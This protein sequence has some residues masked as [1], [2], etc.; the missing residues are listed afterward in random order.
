MFT[1]TERKFYDEFTGL[2]GGGVDYLNALQGDKITCIVK[3]FFYWAVTGVNVNFN[4]GTKTISLFGLS[5][6]T[7]N[8]FLLNGFKIGDSIAIVGS[9]TNDGTYTIANVTDTVITT[10]Q[11]LNT[12]NGPDSSIYG[13]TLIT[14]LDYYFD[15]IDN[16]SQKS[17]FVSATDKGTVQKYSATGLDASVATPVSLSIATQSRG[18]SSDILS[19]NF[20]EGTVIGVSNAGYKQSFKITTVF[21]MTRIWT[22]EL[23]NNFSNRSA[24]EEYKNGNCLKHVC[25]ID[26]KF[27]QYDPIISHTGSLLNQQAATGWFNQSNTQK[28][29]EYT[30]GSIQYQNDATSEYLTQLEGSIINRVTIMINSASGK[31]VSG[32]SQ[33]IINHSLC[34]LDE[35][36]YINTSTTLLQNIRLD[37]KL[38]TSDQAAVNGVNFGGDYQALT[39]IVITNFSA[40]QV[41]I[42]FKID[43]S[44]AT[45]AILKSR[46]DTDRYY[47]FIISCQDV[48]ITTTKNIDRVNV[49]ADFNIADYDMRE[50]TIFG[51]L[52]YF[53]CSKFP[54]AGIFETNEIKGYQGDP[55]YIEIPFYIETAVVDNKT[56]TLLQLA[57]QF[58]STKTGNKD[59]V[60]EEKVFNISDVRKLN[61]IQTIDVQSTRGF[62]LP[63]GSAFNFANIVR[64]AEADSGTQI[65]YKLQYGF[66]LRFEEWI[67]VVQSAVGGSVDIF[68]NV[69]DVV[70]AWKRY[71]TGNG[72]ALNFRMNAV[73]KGYSDLI[74]NFT[75]QVPVTILEDGDAS[76]DG[77]NFETEI[78]YFNSAD[79]EIDAILK[80]EPTR[81]VGAFIGDPTIFPAGMT[82]I[83]GYVVILDE[84]G[85][86]FN[87][88]V[89]TTEMDSESDSPFSVADL[90]VLQNP[91]SQMNSNNLR[92]T[93][94][95]NRIIFDTIYTPP[96]INNSLNML[97]NF[98]I[99]YTPNDILLEENGG[100]Y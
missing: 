58:V 36:V 3:G 80:D 83:K 1:I 64:Y 4:S 33:F 87:R 47:D 11:A 67:Q 54:N 38:V 62:I 30:I 96:Q 56:P 12:E 99:T 26:G 7:T 57:V 18:W 9:P 19:G 94:F 85:T 76:P 78:K 73:M 10:V 63:E 100:G 45:K 39:D 31:F 55:G 59:F 69:K 51:L 37:K 23:I 79:V 27:N 66:V 25:K 35:S 97:V 98:K 14:D 24:P 48:A 89:A 61:N 32:T 91:V 21:Y 50:K 82:T 15:L 52:D 77:T 53:H 41:V 29:A 49:I 74:T 28:Q 6:G 34:P 95:T 88:R 84:F 86:I 90:P 70:Q 43:Y 2:G 13:T 8:S 5:L 46:I 22:N 81:I 65:A 68:K 92:M 42:V 71:S 72:W 20:G 60:I 93:I 16:N 17:D 75:A 40:N 44:A